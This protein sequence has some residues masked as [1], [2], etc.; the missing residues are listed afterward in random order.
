MIYKNKKTGAIIDRPCVISGG[1]WVKVEV[2][3]EVENTEEEVEKK[4]PTRKRT[5]KKE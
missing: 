5:A 3:E 4:Q 1:D 2:E